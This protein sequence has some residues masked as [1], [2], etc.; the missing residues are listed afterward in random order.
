MCQRDEVVCAPPGPRQT[1]RCREDVLEGV[2][3]LIEEGSVTG[4]AA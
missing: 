2:Q 4:V 1:G 3:Q